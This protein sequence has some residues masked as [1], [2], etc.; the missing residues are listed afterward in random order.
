MVIRTPLLAVIFIV[1][2][3][4]MF[5]GL[6]SE[7]QPQ[8]AEEYLALAKTCEKK[9]ENQKRRLL[10]YEKARQEYEEKL[11]RP[12]GHKHKLTDPSHLRKSIRFYEGRIEKIESKINK[13]EALVKKY[14]TNAEELQ[15]REMSHEK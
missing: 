8:T 7:R 15:K 6:S 1:F 4:S 2:L 14:R 9:V 10:E 12:I 13:Y 3:S 5:L 11:A